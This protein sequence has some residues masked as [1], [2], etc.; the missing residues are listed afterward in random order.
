M[1]P[2]ELLQGRKTGVKPTA[3][4]ALPDRPRPRDLEEFFGAQ[5][6]NVRPRRV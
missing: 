6:R 1:S 5:V 4:I 2:D 3:V